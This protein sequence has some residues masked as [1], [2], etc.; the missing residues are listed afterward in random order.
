MSGQAGAR[1]SVVNSFIATQWAKVLSCNSPALRMLT[2]TVA[3]MALMASARNASAISTS[4]SVKPRARQLAGA[5]TS[6][7]IILVRRDIADAVLQIASHAVTIVVIGTMHG[8][9]KWRELA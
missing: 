2:P 7:G 3:M 6:A 1:R 8:D 5:R 4:I 9:G